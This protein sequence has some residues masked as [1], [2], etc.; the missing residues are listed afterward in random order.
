MF[1]EDKNGF[2]NASQSLGYLDHVGSPLE[3]VVTFYH[4]VK[5]WWLFEN[6]EHMLMN[7][8]TP[9]SSFLRHPINILQTEGH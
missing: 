4:H 8:F 2:E 5:C 9:I 3:A 1:V 6:C 7:Y